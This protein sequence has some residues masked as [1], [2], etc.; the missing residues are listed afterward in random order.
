MLLNQNLGWMSQDDYLMN[1]QEQTLREKVMEFCYEFDKF[2][3]FSASGQIR[4][5]LIAVLWNYKLG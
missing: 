2:F 3:Q 4:E 1:Q 5:A